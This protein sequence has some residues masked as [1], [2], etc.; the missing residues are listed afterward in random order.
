MWTSAKTYCTLD[1]DQAWPAR[2]TFPSILVLLL[3]S[4]IQQQHNMEHSQFAK[5]KF[6]NSDFFH[7]FPIKPMTLICYASETTRSSWIQNTHPCRFSRACLDLM[8]ETQWCHFL[9]LLLLRTRVYYPDTVWNF[10]YIFHCPENSAS[11]GHRRA[12]NQS[13]TWFPYQEIPGIY[14]LLGPEQSSS[15]SL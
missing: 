15:T 8:S 11:I 5:G 9:L 2:T 4:N 14:E 7:F 1:R 6:I 10:C 12:W 13:S 3:F